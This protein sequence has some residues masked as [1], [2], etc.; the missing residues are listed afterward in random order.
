MY[1]GYLADQ[2]LA[3]QDAGET[4]ADPRQRPIVQHALARMK[5]GGY[6]EAFARVGF[7]LAGTDEP[8]PLSLLTTAQD[9]IKDYA[10]LLPP[11]P[12]DQWRRVRGEQE[13]IVRYDPERAIE[14]LP[15]LLND[16]EREHLLALIERVVNDKRVL[17]RSPTAQ[18]A[19]MLQRVRNALGGDGFSIRTEKVTTRKRTDVALR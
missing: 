14:T 7:L 17:E 16:D 10:D 18:Q 6:L 5:E 19:A 4:A 12:V 15:R 9:L 2:P 8:I 3:S 11:L 13:I 1:L